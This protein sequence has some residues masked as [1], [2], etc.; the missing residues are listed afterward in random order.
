MK[1]AGY[2]GIIITGKAEKPTYLFIHDGE[3]EFRDA[4]NLWGKTPIRL[5]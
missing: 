5:I 3:V 2:D 4:E 1:K